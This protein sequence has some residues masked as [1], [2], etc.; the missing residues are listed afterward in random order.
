MYHTFEPIT[1]TVQKFKK[2]EVHELHPSVADANNH[3]DI[4]NGIKYC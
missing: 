3:T 4:L 2:N 1:E